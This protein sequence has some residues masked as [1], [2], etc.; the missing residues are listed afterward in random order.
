MQ[1]NVV[2]WLAFG[3]RILPLV[4]SFAVVALCSCCPPTALSMPQCD[5]DSHY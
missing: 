2:A 4:A 1:G 5:C 3:M